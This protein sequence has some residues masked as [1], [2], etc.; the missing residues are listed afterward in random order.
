MSELS[1]WQSGVPCGKHFLAWCADCLADAKMRR[2]GNGAVAYRSDCTV[3]TFCEITGAGYDEAA[4][5]LKATGFRPGAG[6]RP[7]ELNA[8]FGVAGY[9][10]TEH[11]ASL[12]PVELAVED[13]AAGKRCYWVAGRRKGAR[14][15]HAWSVTAEGELRALTR[16]YRYRIFEVTA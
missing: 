5:L 6:A 15:A 10:V 3:A 11:P 1:D 7:A 16:P 2:L 4:E 13:A 9:H 8:A 14:Q 12:L